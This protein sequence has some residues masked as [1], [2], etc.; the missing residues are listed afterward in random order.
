M[1]GGEALAVTFDGLL[2]KTL[3]QLKM[4]NAAIF[5]IKYKVTPP[6]PPFSRCPTLP[7]NPFHSFS[8]PTPHAA[9]VL[10]IVIITHCRNK[11]WASTRGACTIRQ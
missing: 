7:H 3:E 4:L 8:S 9:L 1:G 5:P 2:P 10:V 11:R 6:P